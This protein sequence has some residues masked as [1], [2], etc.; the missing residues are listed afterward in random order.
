MDSHSARMRMQ[1]RIDKY[2]VLKVKLK[3]FLEGY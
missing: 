1:K 2:K 3:C